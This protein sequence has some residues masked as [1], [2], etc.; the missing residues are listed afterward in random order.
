MDGLR[1]EP[2][3]AQELSSHDPVQAPYVIRHLPP[4]E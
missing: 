4:G 2:A 3:P 1:L